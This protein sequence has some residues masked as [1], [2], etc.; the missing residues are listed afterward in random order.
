METITPKDEN[1]KQR[2]LILKSDGTTE[3]LGNEKKNTKVG[4]MLTSQEESI[5]LPLIQGL[6]ASNRSNEASEKSKHENTPFPEKEQTTSL[7]SEEAYDTCE[8]GATKSMYHRNSN[9]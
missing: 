1:V 3:K 9:V 2:T 7:K 8:E 5:L 6:L 4:R